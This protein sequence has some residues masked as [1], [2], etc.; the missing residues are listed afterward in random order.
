MKSE[1]FD[2]S[3]FNAALEGLRDGDS[4]ATEWLFRKLQPP[5]LR[6]LRAREPSFADDL[7]A[8]VWLGVSRALPTFEGNWADFRAFFFTIARR[9]L[10]DHRRNS[11]RGRIQV[12]ET[13]AFDIYEAA[14]STDQA[15][16]ANLS[17]QQ[18]ASTLA[19]MLT[20]DQAEV[21]LL[22]VLAD[23][24]VEQVAAIMQRSATWVR[25]TQHRALRSLAKRLGPSFAVTR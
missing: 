20:D 15:A 24:D 17:G 12:V 10:G 16:L 5:L 4:R 9:R 22:R 6:Y 14:D 23:L 2:Q 19:S 13:M 8:E 7:A 21:L 25:V 11:E 1:P 3:R 18:A